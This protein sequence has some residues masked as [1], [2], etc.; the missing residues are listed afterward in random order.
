[1]EQV[2]AEKSVV[3][4]LYLFVIANP[5]RT[6]LVMSEI[7]KLHIEYGLMWLLTAH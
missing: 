3:H 2:G 7:S 5:T 6:F 1:M 4:F